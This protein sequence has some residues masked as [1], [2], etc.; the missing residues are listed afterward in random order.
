MIYKCNDKG[1]IMRCLFLRSMLFI[2]LSL[3]FNLVHAD[4]SSPRCLTPSHE[5]KAESFYVCYI[6]RDLRHPI[7]D[8]LLLYRRYKYHGC[9][10]SK[11]PCRKLYAKKP[12]CPE[13]QL[14]KFGWFSNYFDALN[15]FYRCAYN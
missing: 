6:S 14:K 9:I 7:S 1:T 8:I 5:P 11:E 15:A 10:I 4:C 13:N 12:H 3:F 2:I